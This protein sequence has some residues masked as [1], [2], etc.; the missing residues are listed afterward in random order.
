[1]GK[2]TDRLEQGSRSH[3]GVCKKCHRGVP[4]LLGL[5]VTYSLVLDSLPVPNHTPFRFFKLRYKF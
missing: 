2:G 5:V 1:M 4:V 3:D